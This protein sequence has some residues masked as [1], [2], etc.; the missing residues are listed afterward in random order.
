MM[1]DEAN[2]RTEFRYDLPI[3][4][5]KPVWVR[6]GE[7][8]YVA[9]ILAWLRAPLEIEIAPGATLANDS[10]VVGPT[11]AESL[12]FQVR[13]FHALHGPSESLS[14]KPFEFALE[15][16]AR[17]AGFEASI[18]QSATSPGA[19]IVIGGSG[20]SVKTEAGRTTSRDVVFLTKLME[21]AW[22]K[23]LNSP[24]QF[25]HGLRNDVLARVLQAD[26]TLVWRCHGRLSGSAKEAEYELLEIPKSFWEALSSVEAADFSPITRAGS[27]SAPV[28]LNGQ[29]I[30][31]ISFDGSDQKIQVRSLAVSR[32]VFHGR[33]R[34]RAP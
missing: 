21:S 16:A 4:G 23:N 25:L 19:D 5:G 22:T 10:F 17:D 32:C 28:K 13:L 9:P 11:F 27:T 26:R 18:A 1:G 7:W 33:W 20:F 12:G 14:K 3:E 8:K 15:I 24:E 29:Q 34:L 2:A 30:Y 31:T 6:E